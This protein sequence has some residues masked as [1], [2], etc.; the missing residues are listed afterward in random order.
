LTQQQDL[1]LALDLLDDEL[2][3]AGG[4]SLSAVRSDEVEFTANI[5]GLMTNVT[6]AAAIGQTM[7]SVDD[8]RGWPDR[9]VVLTC[10]NEQCEQST[11]A[12]AGQGN[13]LTLIEPISRIIPAGA[14]VTVINRV[15]YYSRPDEKGA[16]RLLRQIDGG[17][18]V[19]VGAIE[20]ARFS[21]WDEH[22]EVTTL[23][24]RVRRIVVELSLPGHAV[25]AVR[26]IS[27]RT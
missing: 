5:H 8:G 22:G 3:L 15:R 11:L 20:A 26:E 4:G 14:A 19:L 9:K 21:Y 27:L 13:L 16:L 18:S 1:R 2:R 17:A 23:P 10:W 24:D 6:E 7:L 25:K 12:R